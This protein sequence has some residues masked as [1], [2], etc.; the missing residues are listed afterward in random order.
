VMLRMRVSSSGETGK[1]NL[2][3]WLGGIL[4]AAHTS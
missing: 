3:G 2:R 1:G 4:L